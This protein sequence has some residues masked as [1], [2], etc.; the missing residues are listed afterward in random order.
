MQFSGNK[1]EGIGSEIFA[2]AVNEF[3]FCNSQSIK[4]IYGGSNKDE[5]AEAKYIVKSAARHRNETKK[6]QLAKLCT[7]TFADFILIGN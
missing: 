3:K 7:G 2:L 6:N 4:W 5:E 1:A